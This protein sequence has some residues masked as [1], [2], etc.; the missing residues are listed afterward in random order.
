MIDR[1]KAKANI[2]KRAYDEEHERL[3]DSR[4]ALE[5]MTQRA[6][7]LEAGLAA[8]QRARDASTAGRLALKVEYE[9]LIALLIERVSDLPPDLRSIPPGPGLHWLRRA[10][11][12]FKQ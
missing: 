2:W 9:K 4:L 7:G 3:T 6:S 8:N 12:H 11:T 10:A 1:W 5:A